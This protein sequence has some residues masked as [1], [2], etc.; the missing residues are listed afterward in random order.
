MVHEI[1]FYGNKL[2]QSDF[3]AVI[4]HSS[5]SLMPGWLY[6]LINVGVALV[7]YYLASKYDSVP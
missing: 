5:T 2:F 7:G 3:I 6:N 1:F 4:A